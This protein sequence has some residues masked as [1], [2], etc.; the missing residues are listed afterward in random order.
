MRAFFVQYLKVACVL[1]ICREVWFDVVLTALFDHPA[2]FH[3][4]FAVF[5]LAGINAI[6]AKTLC[7][8]DIAVFGHGLVTALL[9]KGGGRGGYHE[10]EQKKEYTHKIIL[11]QFNA[12]VKRY[13]APDTFI[14]V[15]THN[16]AQVAMMIANTARFFLNFF[17]WT[18][19]LTV[20]VLRS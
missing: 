5:E 11:T 18:G 1:F 17:L 15:I 3:A 10:N 9:G 13:D 7:F 4:L 20:M 16:S 19:S 14:M 8:S 6:A 12:E 2:E